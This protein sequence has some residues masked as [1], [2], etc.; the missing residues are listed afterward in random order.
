MMAARK[1]KSAGTTDC[2]N[3]LYADQMKEIRHHGIRTSDPN[4][5]LE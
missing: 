1:M 2:R 3:H 5:G 4:G